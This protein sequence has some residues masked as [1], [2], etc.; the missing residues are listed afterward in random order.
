L[1]GWREIQAMENGNAARGE[2]IIPGTVRVAAIAVM[3]ESLGVLV[4]LLRRLSLLG[5]PFQGWFEPTVALSSILMTVL[6]FSAASFFA[7][8]PPRERSKTIMATCVIVL[9]AVTAW[10]I[11]RAVAHLLAMTNAGFHQPPTWF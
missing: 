9:S 3:V 1:G 7:V 10:T 4:W 11:Y 5:H 2:S 8:W 6:A